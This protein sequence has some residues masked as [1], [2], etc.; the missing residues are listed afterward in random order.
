MAR[1]NKKTS[2]NLAG[3]LITLVNPSSLVSEQFKTL[4]T[5]IQFTMVDQKLK[6]LVVTSA[7]PNAGKS[8]ISANLAV[9]FAMQGLKVL[10]VECDLR[11]PSV[12]KSFHVSNIK[13]LTNL[14]TDTEARIED[15]LVASEQENLSLLLS[16]PLP[17]NPAE[18]L[19]SNR[20]SQLQAE[21]ENHFDL[22]IF[23]TPPLLGFTDG[24]IMAGRS[25][26]TIFVIRHGV[27]LKENMLKAN[28]ILKRVNAN[29]LGAVYNFAPQST[30]DMSY[31][32][33]YNERD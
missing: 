24:Q 14:L 21:L 27:A 22:I 16:G 33:Y 12:H 32:D 8:T 1:K 26:G 29:V 9:T 10:L 5:N 2:K 25:D 17:P 30:Q 31:Y 4:R 11:R 19:G 23:D 6:T 20:M 7:A 28:E 15:N 18:L 13:G 3:N